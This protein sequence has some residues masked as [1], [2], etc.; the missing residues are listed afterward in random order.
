MKCKICNAENSIYSIENVI[1]EYRAFIDENG[2]I[3]YILPAI[4]EDTLDREIV[5]KK[6]GY[7]YDSEEEL[8]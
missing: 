6:C 7:V 8:L 5:C 4:N 3:D 2:M 1:A